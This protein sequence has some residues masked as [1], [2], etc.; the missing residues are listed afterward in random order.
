MRKALFILT[1]LTFATPALASEW[2]QWRGPQRNGVLP[3]SVPLSTQ[4]TEDGPPL[5][6]KS[7]AIPSN[8][9]GGFSSVITSG[10]RAYVSVVW[11]EDVATETRAIDSIVLRQLGHRSTSQLGKELTAKMEADRKGLS[12][13]LRGG[14]LTDWANKWVEENL[15][16]KQ[17]QNLGSWIVSRFKKGKSAIDM[18]DLDL[19]YK[20]RNR[21]FANHDEMMGWL[22]E[23]DLSPGVVE[24][25]V[26]TVPA[27]RKQAKDTMLCLNIDTGATIWKA[28]F[29]G[30]PTGRGSSS[31]PCVHGDY[32][33]ALGSSHIHCLK[34]SDGS[35]VWSTPLASK[36]PATSP[37]ILPSQNADSPDLVL[38]T[39]PNLT[40][41]N[42]KDGSL[43]WNQK[44]AKGKTTSPAIW[45]NKGR[46][47][48][49]ANAGSEVACI[50]P[51]DGSFIWTAPGG[52]DSTPVIDGNF[53]AVYCKKTDLGL[54]GYTLSGDGAKLL[55]SHV[56]DARRTQ[57]SPIIYE[58]HVYLMG[59]DNHMCVE[60]ASG[61]IKW[62]RKL[63]SNISSPIL[64]DGKILVLGNNGN[65]LLMINASPESNQE[66]AKGKVRAL[67]CPSPALT[68]GK[69]LLRHEDGVRCY[70]LR[71]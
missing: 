39:A 30:E 13:R 55:W 35:K 29:P 52:G 22:N 8:D 62:S 54:S 66:L 48:I 27:T 61:E 24:K 20:I 63:R 59:A 51:L 69:L 25:V 19:L 41:L 16:K 50:N 32:L 18:K 21:R 45:N 5:L 1:C 67:W 68:N 37:M 47:L 28:A 60:A 26:E 43:V 38:F 56:L 12:P 40:A 10:N 58:G 36:G 23:Q 70:D 9:D 46:N 33:I 57:S 49:I 53:M 2:N 34:T 11:H 14:K 42:L 31:T 6:W 3:T 4:W 7:E 15:D 65:D 44:Q 64:A 71:Q 17:T